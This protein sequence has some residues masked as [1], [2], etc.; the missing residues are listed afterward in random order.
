MLIQLINLQMV[1]IVITKL[2]EI[3]Q[4]AKKKLP[5][6]LKKLQVQEFKKKI[7]NLHW[8]NQ[9]K[10]KRKLYMIKLF[11][12]QLKKLRKKWLFKR[13]IRKP[14][15]TIICH[16]MMKRKTSHK[17]KKKKRKRKRRIKKKKKKKKKKR[18]KLKPKKHQLKKLQPRKLRKLQKQIEQV[19][20]TVL[21]T[22]Q[23]IKK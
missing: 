7:R 9:K 8:Y 6:H 21:L 12:K 22:M 15:T 10:K 4:R 11:V 2:K 17:R 3:Q 18:K 16:K 23:S 13:R 20:N 5:M 1:N 14:I 19:T